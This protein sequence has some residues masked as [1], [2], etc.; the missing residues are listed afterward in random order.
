MLVC[1]ILQ[2]QRDIVDELILLLFLDLS[3][4]KPVSLNLLK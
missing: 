2:V 3:K 4:C 1:L